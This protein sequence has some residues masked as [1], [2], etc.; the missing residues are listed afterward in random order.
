MNSKRS[1]L[2]FG[3]MRDHLLYNLSQ[4]VDKIVC[5][6]SVSAQFFFQTHLHTCARIYAMIQKYGLIKVTLL[7]KQTNNRLSQDKCK[8]LR[9]IKIWHSNPEEKDSIE[10]TCFFVVLFLSSDVISDGKDIVDTIYGIM[11]K[12]AN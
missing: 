4:E 9:T 8:F 5:L 11:D 6:E 10:F 7:D 12:Y 1:L 3:D 2:I